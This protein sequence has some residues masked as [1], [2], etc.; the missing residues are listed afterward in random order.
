MAPSPV[1]GDSKYGTMAYGMHMV[2][3]T[4]KFIEVV[5]RFGR[6]GHPK[7]KLFFFGIATLENLGAGHI[8][9]SPQQPK[10]Q[11]GPLCPTV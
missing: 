6:V 9:W 5:F 8:G 10:W 1:L 4:S 2:Y 11:V 3:G 7:P